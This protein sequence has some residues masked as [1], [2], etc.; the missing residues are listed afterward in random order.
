MNIVVNRGPADVHVHNVRGQR[1]KLFFLVGKRIPNFKHRVHLSLNGV[2]LLL[3]PRK[4][5]QLK[6]H[7]PSTRLFTQRR[8]ASFSYLILF[9]TQ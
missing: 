4:Q 6:K 9:C 7:A 5:R 8:C 1:M 3:Y 2:C